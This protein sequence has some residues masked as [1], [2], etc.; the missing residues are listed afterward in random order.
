MNGINI[1]RLQ[2][3]AMY[4]GAALQHTL[5]ICNGNGP[6][7]TINVLQYKTKFTDI[8][9]YCRLADKKLVW[10]Y[11]NFANKG[12]PTPEF[13]KNRL[14]CDAQHYR[15]CHMEMKNF[16]LPEEW[17][18]LKNPADYCELLCENKQE[19][20][21][22]IDQKLELS[23]KH[24]GHIDYLY[25]RW[26]VENHEELEKYLCKVCKFELPYIHAKNSVVHRHT[27]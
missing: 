17:A 23:K 12:E 22:L 15:D 5:P 3:V 20:K 11:W 24:S 1:G 21:N 7:S 13:F 14:F 2:S 26:E 18:C 16:L 8:R 25:K 10:E 19:L 4:V 27:P 9:I 6:V